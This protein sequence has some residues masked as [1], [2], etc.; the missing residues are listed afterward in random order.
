MQQT[1]DCY[2][3]MTDISSYNSQLTHV[4]LLHIEK[5]GQAVL[6]YVFIMVFPTSPML[7]SLYIV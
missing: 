5:R 6:P 7:N 3:F 1:S 2:S 4:Y